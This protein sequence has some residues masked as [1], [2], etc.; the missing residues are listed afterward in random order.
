MQVRVTLL[1]QP[2]TA[3][4]M[5]PIPIAIPLRFDGVGP[6]CFY[7]PLPEASPVVAGDF[8]GSTAQGG[9]VNFM[10]LRINP[11][12]NGTHTE[13]VGHIAATPHYLT[14]CLQ[15]FHFPARLVSLYPQQQPNGDRVIVREQLA[16]VL[17]PSEVAAVVLR[18]LPNRDDKQ[19]RGYSGTNPPYLQHEAAQLLVDYGI[20]HL[21]LDLPSVDREEDEGRLLAHRAFWQYPYATR[22]NATITEMVYVPDAVVDG[23]YLLQFQITAMVLDASPSMPVLYELVAGD[24]K[25]SI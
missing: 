13:C 16:Q 6:N 4:L 18:T 24:E 2:Y 11:H 15:T 14:D 17:T 1:G 19:Q 12:G 21:L 7:A 9:L 23:L 3:D 8:I 22:K 10:N 5:R 20:D 25:S